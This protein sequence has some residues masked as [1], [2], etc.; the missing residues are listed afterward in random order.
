[1]TNSR[2]QQLQKLLDAS[3]G[4]AFLRYAI[5][6]EY[7]SLGEVGRALHGY[8]ELLDLQPEYVGA[9]LHLGHLLERT[10]DLPAALATYQRGMVVAQNLGDRHAFN[11]LASAKMLLDDSDDAD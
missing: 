9:Y 2:L 3:P 7:E 5:A 8:V 4:D 10:G 6:K 11:E 1:M